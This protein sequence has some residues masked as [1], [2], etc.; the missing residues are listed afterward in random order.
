MTT[1]RAMRS[2]H[3]VT[4]PSSVDAF[5]IAALGL[6]PLLGAELADLGIPNRVVPGGVEFRADE[7]TLARVN[8]RSRLAS[9]VLVRLAQFRAT[10]FHELERAARQVAW[11]RVLAP[12]ASVAVRVTC[13]KSRLYH[14]DAVAQRVL[15][16]MQRAIPQLQI[17]TAAA[18]DTDEDEPSAVPQRFVVRFD[19]DVCTISADTSGALLHRRGYRLAVGRAP[20]RETLAAA[21]LRGAAW[22]PATPLL[23]PMCGSG[24]IAI[25]AA[26]LARRIAPGL[27]RRFAAE[28][29]PTSDP[30]VWEAARAAAR[31]E[32][33][34]QAPAPIVAS[35]RDAGAIAN[36]TANAARAGV[37]A[38]I[39]FRCAPLS[40]LTWPEGAGG[41][42]LANPPYGVRV[43]ETQ[44]LRDLFARLG[45]LVRAH[46]AGWRVALLS[47][48]RRLEGAVRLPFTE[49]LATRNGGIPVRLI[50]TPPITSS[51]PAS[52]GA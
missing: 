27:H 19:H 49:V 36:A 14:S 43:G 21:M 22:D 17:G 29:W 1:P 40:A 46:G 32:I 30:A 37:A 34:P 9:R 42:L 13:R 24:T 44:G 10:A 35:D 20:L 51:D 31:A 41:L 11:G 4:V 12:G 18:D 38:D 45:Q 52:Q 16:A 50:R 28:Q 6:E 23:D 39:T 3:T 25:E 2:A 8:L 47:A 26:M 33:L 7:A 5:A 15:E 48:D